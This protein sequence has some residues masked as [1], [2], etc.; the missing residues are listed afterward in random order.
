MRTVKLHRVVLSIVDI[1]E[2]GAELVRHEI[3]RF[4]Y[5]NDCITPS[6]ISIE[7]WDIGEWHDNHP[8]N[9]NETAVAAREHLFSTPPESKLGGE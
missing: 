5:P 7:T 1:D 3:E 8:L 6:V 4:S 9:K 2:L